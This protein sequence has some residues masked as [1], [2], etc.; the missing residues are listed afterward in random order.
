MRLDFVD[1]YLIVDGLRIRYWDEGTGPS[2]LLIHGIGVAAEVWSWNIEELSR[3]YRVIAFD[4]PGCGKSERTERPEIYNQDNIGTF[5]AKLTEALGIN[6]VSVIGNSLGG[7]IALSFA[8]S[9]P[10]LIDKLILV[11]SA[12][13]GHEI[14]LP[15]RLATIPMAGEILFKPTRLATKLTTFFTV[16]NYRN[17]PSEF[18]DR[19]FRYSKIPGTTEAMLRILRSG[20]NIQGQYAYF[21]H[22]ELQ[23]ITSPTMIL[24]GKQDR[25]LPVNH[26]TNALQVIPNCHAVIL[27]KAGHG[28]MI[29]CPYKFNRLTLEFL[30]NGKLTKEH[31]DVSDDL[32]QR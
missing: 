30:R 12:G 22:Q 17:I 10:T 20:V 21:S 29:D 14:F 28:P 25:A 15:L 32:L 2:L 19:L 4:I 24:W 8:L 26:V 5:L 13:L 23:R 1:K 27:D 9:H 6:R 11:D 16:F 7:F 3:S 31:L 18:I